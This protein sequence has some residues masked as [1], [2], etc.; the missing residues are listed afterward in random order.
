LEADYPERVSDQPQWGAK[1]QVRFEPGPV[2]DRIK[3][4]EDRGRFPVSFDLDTQHW[5]TASGHNW[6]RLKKGEAVAVITGQQPCLW[7]G[8]SLVLHKV[9]SALNIARWLEGEGVRAVPVFWNAS[10]DHDLA[11]MLRVGTLDGH[12]DTKTIKKIPAEKAL[13]AEV[14]EAMALEKDQLHCSTLVQEAFSQGA[15]RFA[16][17]GSRALLHLFKEQGLV[18]VEPRDLAP[19]SLPF[20]AKVEECQE[21]LI[22]AYDHCESNIL[23]EGR[24][25]QAPRRH[26]LPIFGIEEKHGSRLACSAILKDEVFSLS[27]LKNLGYRPSPGALLRPLMAQWMM[28]IAVTVLGPAEVKYH[29]QLMGGFGVLGIE[30]PLIWPRLGG[31]WVPAETQSRLEAMGL[32]AREVLEKGRVEVPL[33]SSRDSAIRGLSTYLMALRQEGVG[34][35]GGAQVLDRL[36]R[37]LFSALGRFERG[38]LRETLSSKGVRPQEADRLLRF[39]LPRGA[40]QERTLGWA[41]ILRDRAHLEEIQMAFADPFDNSHRIY[42]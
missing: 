19:A 3:R 7:G 12:G 40:Y 6:S 42:R 37:D 13:A 20:W 22:K 23:K 2:L 25:L 28:P 35:L 24:S 32:S 29:E 26:R 27:L 38:L 30:A 41:S 4:A 1:V 18:V 17:Q 15:R 34:R 14:L 21:D 8:P 11:E 16:E 36:D 39:L 9:I 10:E 31:T 5:P 33:D